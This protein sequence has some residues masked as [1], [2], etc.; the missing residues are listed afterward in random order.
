M[1]EMIFTTLTKAARTLSLMAAV[2]LGAQAATAQNMFAPVVRVDSMVV[3]EFEVQQR[4]RFLQLLNAPGSDRDSVVEGLIDDRLRNRAATDV[5]LELTEEGTQTGLS[6]FAARANLTTE[7]FTKALEQSGVAR[8]TFRDYVTTSLIWRE[9]IRARYLNSVNITEAEIDRAMGASRGGSGLR[10]LVSEIIIPAPPPQAARV[11]ALAGQISQSTSEAEFSSYAR[12]YSATA[13][14]GAGGRLPWTPLSKLPPSLQ[15]LLLALAPGEVTS[16]LPIPNAVALFQLRAIEETGTPTP[17]YSA[18]EYAAYFIPGGRSEAA[19]AEA[20]RIQ[21]KVDVC[22]DLYGIAKG[23]PAEVLARETK[24]PGELPKDY[25]IELSK[26]D[27]GE[28]STALTRANGQNLV[29]LMLCKRTAEANAETDRD[30]VL[31]AL[32]QQ[33]LQGYSN[34]LLQQ[35]RA[36]A[37]IIYK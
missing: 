17:S 19:L 20:A 23:Q 8:E 15:P 13:S 5:G 26:L 11:N 18:I 27:P 28:T 3:T 31:S 12:K 36:E 35:L 6:E 22:D 25:A 9:L 4:Q 1:S 14:R 32:R 2:T 34:Q 24:K 16:P 29:L 10:V 21:G 7:E 37:R 30:A 33:K